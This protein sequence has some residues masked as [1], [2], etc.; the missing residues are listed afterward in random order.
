MDAMLTVDFDRFP[1]GPGDRVLDLGAG[2]GRHTYEILRRG[3]EA[4]AVDLNVDD[5]HQVEAMV[6]AMA[7]E[8]EI[9][10]PAG[11]VTRLADALALPFADG[12]FDRVIAAEILE[13]LPDD[14]GAIAEIARVTTPG[15]HVAVTVPRRWP[16][17]VCWALSDAYH[18][19]E[20]GHVRIY[21]ASELRAS[22]EAAGL[23][24]VGSHHAHALHAPYWWLRCAVGV[25]HE[26]AATRAYHRL[27]VWDMMSR[28]AL[29]RLG[30]RLLNPVLGKS[31]VLYFRKPL[32]PLAQDQANG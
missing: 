16:E 14:R 5:L 29:T 30:E 4:V 1:V 15:G 32:S 18:E 19:V 21:R 13:H 8:G 31:V 22:V 24:F 9:G 3:A 23:T 7:L 2:Q 11:P 28:P 26:T 12:H 20:G 10:T 17:Q 6:G 25:D 27:L